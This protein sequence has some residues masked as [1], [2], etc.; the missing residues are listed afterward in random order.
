[1]ALDIA[2]TFCSNHMCYMVKVT[3]Y[4]ANNSII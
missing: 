2:I 1:L 4:Y 3:Q